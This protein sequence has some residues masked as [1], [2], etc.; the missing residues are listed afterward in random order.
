MSQD[1]A[2]RFHAY[3]K[4]WGDG[5][6]VRAINQAAEHHENAAIRQAYLDG[7]TSG[8]QER[9]RASSWA[10][11]V[12]GYEPSI[13]RAMSEPTPSTAATPCNYS[14]EGVE[15]C[16]KC[17]WAPKR[18]DAHAETPEEAKARRRRVRER[19]NPTPRVLDGE[20]DG[21]IQPYMSHGHDSCPPT[22]SIRQRRDDGE[23]EGK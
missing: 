22:C 4:G 23:R 13:L 3:M 14:H 6:G 21:C 10:S 16:M 15:V 5:A 12:T 17:G 9:R 2:N 7:Y 11:S 19:I 8:Q 20:D 1:A 18:E